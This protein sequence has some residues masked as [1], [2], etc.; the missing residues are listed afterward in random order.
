MNY[1]IF[2]NE[3]P[4]FIKCFTRE[5]MLETATKHQDVVVACIESDSPLKIRNPRLRM[6]IDDDINVARKVLDRD[7]DIENFLEKQDEK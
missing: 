7:M 5:D 2:L 3:E 4:Y 6:H 1:A